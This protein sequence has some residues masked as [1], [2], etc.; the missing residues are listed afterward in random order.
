MAFISTF[1][2]DQQVVPFA[3]APVTTGTNCPWY[4]AK[5]IIYTNTP[6]PAKTRV[7]ADLTQ[8]T[9]AGY[10]AQT[11]TWTTAIRD[12][13]GL[14]AVLSNLITFREAGAIT[15]TTVYGYA[16]TDAAGTNLLGLEAFP[17]PLALT[18]ALSVISIVADIQ[19]GIGVTGSATVTT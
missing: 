18:D 17:S 10:V 9:Y 1:Y 13:A 7:L 11:I 14:I 5:M 3:T 4:Q 8:P 6:Q 19:L 12:A 2:G 15:Q 16:I